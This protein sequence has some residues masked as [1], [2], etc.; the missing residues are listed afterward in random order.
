MQTLNQFAEQVRQSYSNQCALPFLTEQVVLEDSG[1]LRAGARDYT[2]SP[3][4]LAQFAQLSGISIKAFLAI[5]PDLRAEH[6]NRRLREKRAGGKFGS[7]IHLTFDK[8]GRILGFD[9]RGLLKI[10]AA[11]LIQIVMVS[12]PAGL[13]PGRVEVS[14]IHC[15]PTILSFSCFTLQEAIAPRA[16]DVVNGGIDVHHSITG[17]F[18]TQIRCYLRRL[19]CKNG[20]TVH[21]CRNSNHTYPFAG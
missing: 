8:D 20:A 9:K 18:A 5:D 12:L 2:L 7:E 16:G 14:R 3:E 11:G 4:A 21:I 1:T 17:E 6:F 19:V 10:V 15:S 13:P